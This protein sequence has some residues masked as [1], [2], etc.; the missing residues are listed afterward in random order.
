MEYENSAEARTARCPNPLSTLELTQLALEDTRRSDPEW[1][2]AVRLL[3]AEC[4]KPWFPAL[5]IEL[6]ERAVQVVSDRAKS[7]YESLLSG[8]PSIYGIDFRRPRIE[9]VVRTFLMD[10]SALC[11]EAAKNQIEEF[12]SWYCLHRRNASSLPD[13]LWF[14]LITELVSGH[15]SACRPRGV[16]ADGLQTVHALYTSLL[17][18]RDRIQASIAEALNPKSIASWDKQLLT[19][20]SNIPSELSDTLLLA[21]DAR[22][23]RR[24][25]QTIHIALSKDDVAALRAWLEE[26]SMVIAPSVMAPNNLDLPKGPN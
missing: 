9:A 6:D 20:T 10:I 1:V 2:F 3:S 21:I 19:H 25:W 24:F 16:S 5:A 23:F 11:G 14:A 8:S 13:S 7:A 26:E 17:Q 12:G 4:V 18:E 15:A 22:A